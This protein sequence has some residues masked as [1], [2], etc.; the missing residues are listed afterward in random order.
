MILISRSLARRQGLVSEEGDPFTLLNAYDEWI[1]VKGARGEDSRKWCRRHG[2]EEQRLYEITRLKDQFG[3]LLKDAGLLREE[4]VVQARN[5]VA[6]SNPDRSWKRQQLRKLQREREQNKKR[7]VLE[8]EDADGGEEEA[9]GDEDDAQGEGSGVGGK[10]E[11][12]LKGLE[13]ELSYDLQTMSDVSTRDLTVQQVNII[14]FC[15]ASSLYPNVAVADAANVNR[16]IQD[17]L[18]GTFKKREA[19][20]HPTSVYGSAPSLVG[21]SDMLTYSQILETS[22]PYLMNAT[23]A[24]FLQ[25]LLLVCSSIDVGRSGTCVLIDDW[26]E[27]NFKGGQAAERAIYVTQRLRM[28]LTSC[29][30]SRLSSSAPPRSGISSS[31]PPPGSVP[32]LLQQLLDEDRGGGGEE[33]ELA[34]KVAELMESD[35]KYTVRVPSRSH[36]LWKLLHPSVR[37]LGSSAQVMK[38]TPWCLTL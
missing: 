26:L 30:A 25:T 13:F 14:K 4:T 15:L 38:H 7:K 22:K 2:L 28:M 36:V 5:R 33:G 27:V 31:A 35:L 20:M 21:Q 1:K 9:G 6:R 24:P 23:K 18:F 12:D 29:L 19:C 10:G 34:S 3:N 16:K 37:G 11:V 8:M 32:T 17:A